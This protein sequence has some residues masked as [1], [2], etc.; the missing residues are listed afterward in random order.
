MSLL[1][2]ECNVLLCIEVS[3]PIKCVKCNI[4]CVWSAMSL[5]SIEVS[6]P[7]K[8]V[9]CNVPVVCGV[10]CPLCVEYNV[11]VVCGVQCPCCVECNVPVVY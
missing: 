11:P 5:L 3:V 1:C 10:Q 2:V 4:H 7:I 9:E 6:V 8:Y